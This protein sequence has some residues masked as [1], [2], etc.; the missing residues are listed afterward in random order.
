MMA[1]IAADLITYLKTI[2]AVTTLVGAGTSARIYSHASKQGVALPYIVFEVYEGTSSE[3]L[4]GISGL[5]SNRIEIWTYESTSA[6]AYTLAEAV[7]LAPLQMLNHST[8]GSTYVHGVNS[9]GSYRR[10]FDPPVKGSNQK[11]Y[12]ISRDYIFHYTEAITA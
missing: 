12:W 10:G 6:K 4:G 5:A 8:V 3:H 7:R 1:D 11:R 9:N 2:S